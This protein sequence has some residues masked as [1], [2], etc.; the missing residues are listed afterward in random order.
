MQWRCSQIVMFVSVSK[1]RIPVCSI[2]T[3]LFGG[4]ITLLTAIIFSSNS[5]HEQKQVRFLSVKSCLV[6]YPFATPG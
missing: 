5:I 3:S 1:I 2:F 6:I 4:S